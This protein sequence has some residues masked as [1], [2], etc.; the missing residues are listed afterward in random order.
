[1]S[2]NEA[3]ET[4]DEEK[5]RVEADLTTLSDNGSVCSQAL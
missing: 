5:D 3:L 4:D 1:M 2:E